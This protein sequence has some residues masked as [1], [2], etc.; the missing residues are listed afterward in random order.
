[1][2]TGDFQKH[3]ASFCK[4]LEASN[5]GPVA[6]QFSRVIKIFDGQE[7]IMLAKFVKLAAPTENVQN[8]SSDV[9]LS[10]LLN[11]L[12]E[13]ERF[14]TPCSKQAFLKDLR[15]F[16]NL[17]AGAKNTSI[18][19]FVEIVQA[20]LAAGPKISRRKPMATNKAIVEAYVARLKADYKNTVAFKFIYQELIS[21]KAVR[22]QEA[23]AISDQFAYA[24][25]P[26]TAKKASLE[27]ILSVHEHYHSSVLREKA[28]DGR[29]AA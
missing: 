25:P 3:L 13:L 12:A 6:Q 22:K 8:H 18:T 17:L 23:A 10:D 4:I 14:L 28:M 26:S 19:D 16:T 15:L 20:Q 7:D 29:S 5:A 11:P 27:R 9:L 2:K 24:T 1:M 21:N